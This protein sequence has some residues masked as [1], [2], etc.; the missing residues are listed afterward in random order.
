VSKTPY[1]VGY[2]SSITRKQVYVLEQP[3][4]YE[5]VMLHVLD[6]DDGSWFEPVRFNGGFDRVRGGDGF[7]QLKSLDEFGV[8]ETFVPCCVCSDVE[9]VRFD[10]DGNTK[11]IASDPLNGDAG[12]DRQGNLLVT[13]FDSILLFR[14]PDYDEDVVAKFSDDSFSEALS[15]PL[16]CSEAE[17]DCPGIPRTED[18]GFKETKLKFSGAADK[19]FARGKLTACECEI[20]CADADHWMLR[21]ATGRC[22]CY[23]GYLKKTVRKRGYVSSDL[24]LVPISP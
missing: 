10:A 1:A 7:S 2:W 24:T 17:G 21:L 13:R 15:G 19:S 4:E 8:V 18:C 20:A 3:D 5:A 23:N 11:S 16:K 12:F 9:W 14:Y 6:L 22:F